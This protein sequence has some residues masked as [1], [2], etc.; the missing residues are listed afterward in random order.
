MSL[1]SEE[2]DKHREEAPFETRVKYPYVGPREREREGKS[3]LS[4]HQTK[5]AKS[6]QTINMLPLPHPRANTEGGANGRG[7]NRGGARGEEL[8]GEG[9]V[10]EEPMEKRAGHGGADQTKGDNRYG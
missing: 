4:G 9:P 2:V 5:R 7:T 10:G 8:T 1:K 6:D 3:Q